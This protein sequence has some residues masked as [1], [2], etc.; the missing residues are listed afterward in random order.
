MKAAIVALRVQARLALDDVYIA[1]EDVIAHLTRS[2]LH[3]SLQRHGISPLPKG[4]REKPRKFKDYEIG[5]FHIDIADKPV[6]ALTSNGQATWYTYRL[7]GMDRSR[8]VRRLHIGGLLNI[9]A[10]RE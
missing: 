7:D 5:Y 2:S 3:R 6:A 1:L 8:N 4:D 9:L 10:T